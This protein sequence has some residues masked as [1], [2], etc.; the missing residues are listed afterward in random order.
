MLKKFSRTSLIALQQHGASI[1]CRNMAHQL[2]AA[3]WRII[4]FRNMAHQLIVKDKSSRIFGIV[5]LLQ[6]IYQL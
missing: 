5:N 3:T 4:D 1:D 2:I 6:C